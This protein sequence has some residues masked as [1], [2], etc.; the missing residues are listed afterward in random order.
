MS[1]QNSRKK[2]KISLSPI[3]NEIF[4]QLTEEKRRRFNQ[5]CCMCSKKFLLFRLFL[6]GEIPLKKVPLMALCACECYQIRR[7]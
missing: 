5:L 3:R 7:G 4:L 6:F 2:K 1:Y